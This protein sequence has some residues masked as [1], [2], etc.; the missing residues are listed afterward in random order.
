[1]GRVLHAS[2]SGYFPTCIQAQ[3]PSIADLQARYSGTASSIELM[4]ALYWRVREWEVTYQSQEDGGG[5]VTATG[6][7]G[8]DTSTEE[9]LVCAPQFIEKSFLSNIGF[10]QEHSFSIFSLF[11][12]LFYSVTSLDNNNS[13]NYAFQTLYYGADD[14][15]EGGFIYSGHIAS[16]LGPEAIEETRG[17]QIAGTGIAPF[18]ITKLPDIAN[19]YAQFTIT[20]KNYW[21]YG[22]LYNEATGQLL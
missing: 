8:F 1:M 13:F 3:L 17:L 19:N 5:T 7:Y 21:S 22:G 12:N 10:F 4:M 2:A 20:P 16:E 6:I 15:S 14:G 11:P 9:G 18:K